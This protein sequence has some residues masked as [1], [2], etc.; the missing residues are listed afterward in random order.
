VVELV[1]QYNGHH[2]CAVFA[3]TCIGKEDP[4][5]GLPW[6]KK[7]NPEV[8][9]TIGRVKMSCCPS[10]CSTCHEEVQTKCKAHYLEVH[11]I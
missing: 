5:L 3:V 9:S 11:Q 10:V 1:L 6:L 4:I 2:E 7:H 8:E